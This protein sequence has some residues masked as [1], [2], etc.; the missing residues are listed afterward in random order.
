MSRK[1]AQIPVQPRPPSRKYLHSTRE[2]VVEY[3][4]AG[5]AY[6]IAA[7]IEVDDLRAL[8]AFMDT[9]EINEVNVAVRAA[10]QMAVTLGPK[11]PILDRLKQRAAI[12]ELRVHFIR[13]HSEATQAIIAEMHEMLAG[14][15]DELAQLAA[16]IANTPHPEE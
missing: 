2:K 1:P 11:I 9:Y 7:Q 14:T 15:E 6:K 12:N 4:N 16:E 5:K 3:I 8:L 10:I 13:R